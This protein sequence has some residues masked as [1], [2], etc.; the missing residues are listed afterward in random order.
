[1]ISFS[2]RHRYF[3]YLPPTDMRKS[4]AGLGG[5]VK[6]SLG[7]ELTSGDIFIFINRR[8]DRLKLLMWD[9]SGFVIWY[10]RLEEGS[11]ELPRHQVGA[12]GIEIRRDDLM[13][14]LEGIELWSVRRRKRYAHPVPD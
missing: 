14:I 11:F 10:K 1:M 8:R 13:L 5:I 9:R 12:T 4:F 3:L 7:K 6:R 2:N